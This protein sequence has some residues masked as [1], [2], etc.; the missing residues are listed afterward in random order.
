MIR[1][2]IKRFRQCENGGVIILVTFAVFFLIAAAG[3]AFD[4]ARMQTARVKLATCLDAAG[5]AALSKVGSTPSGMTVNAWVAQ[6]VKKYF[7][8][9]CQSG[10]LNTAAVSFNGN[11]QMNNI[12]AVLSPDFGTLTLDAVL[13]QDMKLIPVVGINQV[14][15]TAHSVVTRSTTGLELALVLD[16]TGSMNGQVNPGNSA[17]SK[18]IALKCALAGNA[19]FGGGSTCTSNGL[20]TTGLLDILF[21][22]N[23]TAPNLFVGIIPFT[24]MVNVGV[25]SPP[26]SGFVDNVTPANQASMTGCVDARDQ[27]WKSVTDSSIHVASGD[28]IMLDISDDPP[29]VIAPKTYFHALPFST[30]FNGR[31]V[32]NGNC[33]RAQVMPMSVSK[34]T[35]V[36][37]VR[38]MQAGGTTMLAMGLTWGWRM[39]SPNWSGLWGSTPAFTSPSGG[40]VPLPLPYHTAGMSKVVVFMTDGM[41]HNGSG[42]DYVNTNPNDD[43]AYDDQATFPTNIREDALTRDVCDAMKS[44]GIIIYTIGF[45]QAAAHSPPTNSE[46]ANDLLVDAPLL[47]Y[48]ASDP[49]KFFLAPTNAQLGQAFQQIGNELANLRVSQ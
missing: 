13:K 41:N 37:E 45:G 24:V 35:A 36:A 9:D 43:N 12:S 26:G 21:G 10:Y 31:L 8:A 40:S 14:I 6:N 3:I 1:D 2:N 4:M 28:V 32:T 38:N 22:N 34:K 48:C 25:T 15:I 7:L 18:I 20:V 23:N 42:S 5:L 47:K 27:M 19:A 33:P 17:V 39:L 44:Q 30:I 49:S 11:R 29:N 16:N 46:R